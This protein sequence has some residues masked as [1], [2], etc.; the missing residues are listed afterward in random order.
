MFFFDII[1][2]ALGYCTRFGPEKLLTCVWYE[3]AFGREV[4]MHHSEPNDDFCVGRVYGNITPN[5]AESINLMGNLTIPMGIIN[6][7]GRYNEYVIYKPEQAIM[8][9]MVQISPPE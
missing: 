8:R 9:Y 3:V 5:A 4:T 1:T 2:K 6:G 7:G